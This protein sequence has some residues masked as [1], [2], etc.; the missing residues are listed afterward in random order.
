[1]SHP[2]LSNSTYS[3]RAFACSCVCWCS[4]ALLLPY[5][6]N[7]LCRASAC[8]MRACVCVCVHPYHRISIS[9]PLPFPSFRSSSFVSSFP[10]LFNR[11]VC[12]WPGRLSNR[13]ALC[14]NISSPR[15]S[16]RSF[17][18]RGM[19]ARTH[20]RTRMHLT[21]RGAAMRRLHGHPRFSSTP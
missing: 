9:P 19:H 13:R 16:L 1:M 4:F 15:H 2:V 12:V 21:V 20:A 7:L 8:F 14:E 18:A 10:P 11:G 3:S 17:L 5:C 6:T